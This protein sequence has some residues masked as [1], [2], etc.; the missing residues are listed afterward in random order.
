[1][2]HRRQHDLAMVSTRKAE[3]ERDGATRLASGLS[4]A[5]A[6]VTAPSSLLAA[7]HGQHGP[8][9]RRRMAARDLSG[10]ELMPG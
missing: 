1:M 2:V 8:T 3:K 9:D 4:L 6:A 5:L 7:R 10:V